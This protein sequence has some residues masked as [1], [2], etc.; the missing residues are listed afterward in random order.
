M[1]QVSTLVPYHLPHLFMNST[2]IIISYYQFVHGYN[3]FHIVEY[4]AHLRAQ[5][6]IITTKDMVFLVQALNHTY[7][8]CLP[9]H[10]KRTRTIKAKNMGEGIGS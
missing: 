8:T 4:I 3:Y 7:A 5:N 6:H 9:V 2:I 10:E 1:F